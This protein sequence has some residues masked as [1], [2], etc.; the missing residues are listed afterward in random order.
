MQ[1]RAGETAHDRATRYASDFRY[2][3]VAK[4][5]DADQLQH[6][7]LFVGKAEDGMLKIVQQ[8]PVL[9]QRFAILCG[10]PLGTDTLVLGM[11]ISNPSA[12]QFVAPDYPHSVL[13]PALQLI[14]GLCW[15]GALEILLACHLHQIVGIGL[16]TGQRERES[17]QRRQHRAELPTHA[18]VIPYL[19]KLE[20]HATRPIPVRGKPAAHLFH[21]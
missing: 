21:F 12:A 3:A 16:R 20:N 6:A 2:L 8:S 14:P 15:R 17:V 9:G 10:C 18:V 13:Q 19:F 11:S 7:A 5:L 4:P 1:A